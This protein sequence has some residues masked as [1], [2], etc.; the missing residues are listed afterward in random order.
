MSLM[1]PPEW[2]SERQDIEV[3]LPYIALPGEETRPT[4]DLGWF[5]RYLPGQSSLT[6]LLLHGTGG[7]ET[8]LLCFGRRVAPGAGLLSVRGRS[9]DE[10]SPRFF[11][12]FDAFTYD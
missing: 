12:R 6:L 1:L 4:R 9:L 10:G 5:H 7:D 2:E 3:T 8:S 11:R